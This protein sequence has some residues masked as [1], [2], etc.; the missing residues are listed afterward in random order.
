MESPL[1]CSVLL[2]T[3]HG[4]N[5]QYQDGIMNYCG[6]EVEVG[7][8]RILPGI[9]Y[10]IVAKFHLWSLLNP[11]ATEYTPLAGFLTRCWGDGTE[12]VSQC[13]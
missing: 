11:P 13:D 10:Y 2:H 3:S 7:V 12:Y 4:G 1:K 8:T 9:E 6:V 5:F